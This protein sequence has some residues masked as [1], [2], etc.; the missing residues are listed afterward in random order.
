MGSGLKNYTGFSTR[1]RL[2]LP[3]KN[4][5]RQTRYYRGTGETSSLACPEFDKGKSNTFLL[6]EWRLLLAAGIENIMLLDSS[7]THHGR[8]ARR[9][10]G[11]KALGSGFMLSSY[12][13]NSQKL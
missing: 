1:L 11:Y 9:V 12:R 4:S 5:S 10:I 2:S 3:S 7:A 13:I 6:F 8:L